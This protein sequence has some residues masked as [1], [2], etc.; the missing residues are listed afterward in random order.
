MSLI[1]TNLN[2]SSKKIQPLL[3][4]IKN[5]EIISLSN[6]SIKRLTSLNLPVTPLILTNSHSISLG[7]KKEIIKE[8][9][10]Q[11]SS[12]THPDIIKTLEITPGISSLQYEFR[13]TALIEELPNHSIVIVGGYGLRYMTKGIFYKFHQNTD[14]LY[15][16]GFNQPDSAIILEKD[17][18]LPR[19]YKMTLFCLPKNKN[20]EKWDG[21][22]CGVENA[23]KYFK[24]DES[25][26][27]NQFGKKLQEIITRKSKELGKFPMVYTNAPLKVNVIDDALPAEQQI[28]DTFH[29]SATARTMSIGNTDPGASDQLATLSGQLRH[30]VLNVPKDLWPKES[31]T[32]SRN[33]DVIKSIIPLIN[34]FRLIKSTNEINLL[35][36]VGDITGEAFIETFKGTKPGL[37]ESHLEAIFEY[38]V[39]MRN[40]QFLSYIPVVASGKNSLCLHYVDNNGKLKEGDLILMDAGAE[41]YH[42]VSDVTRTWPVSGKFTEPQREIYQLLL[43]IQKKC[44]NMCTVTSG[45][46]LNQIHQRFIDL[47]AQ[48]LS[49]VFNRQLSWME[50]ND[51]CPHHIGHYMGLD[52]HDTEDVSRSLP[53]KKGMVIT[54]EPGIYIPYDDR[55][56]SKYQG[57]GIRIEDDIVVGEKKPINLTISV[58]KEIHEIE[59]IMAEQK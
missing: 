30:L 34:N 48:E 39:K 12:Y 27:I 47:L 1:S 6:K 38:N 32:Y 52:V 58:P 51:I 46:T 55:Y 28:I 9:I 4:N 20:L 40:A 57:I 17:T 35:K 54:I 45:N 26:P 7:S 36:K 42:Y 23:I 49:K 5:K 41:L 3:T 31:S 10:G 21:P 8:N 33:P 22:R 11:I 25:F 53:L 24:A 19:K 13:R 15:L 37:S 14:F 44:I 50:T 2:F 56:P 29:Y 59:A 18:S 43:D 16:T